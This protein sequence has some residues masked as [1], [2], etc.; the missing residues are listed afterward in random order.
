MELK[1]FHIS[2]REIQLLLLQLART[3]VLSLSLRA[4]LSLA[5]RFPGVSSGYACCRKVPS[6]SQ[7]KECPQLWNC[8]LGWT[9]S[10][11]TLQAFLKMKRNVKTTSD[12]VQ[13]S[14]YSKVARLD[15]TVP[16][17]R[18]KPQQPY[19]VTHVIGGG[20]TCCSSRNNSNTQLRRKKRLI[21]ITFHIMIRLNK[22][23]TLNTLGLAR[24]KDADRVMR[25]YRWQ[26]ATQDIMRRRYQETFI[27]KPA[28]G[29]HLFVFP[30]KTPAPLFRPVVF[31]RYIGSAV[32]R[33]RVLLITRE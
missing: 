21:I 25:L 13:R 11:G 22:W 9:R 30:C 14:H 20:V 27:L 31:C 26:K 5:V 15:T 18:L 10:N 33:G 4:T 1:H 23:Y 19:L 32:L 7:V 6:A 12:G 2:S 16:V 3:L 24:D 8:L 28:K 17:K 29:G